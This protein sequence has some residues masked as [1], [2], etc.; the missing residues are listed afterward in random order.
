MKFVECALRLLQGRIKA[1]L[2]DGYKIMGYEGSSIY[3][4]IYV[5]GALREIYSA[6]PNDLDWEVIE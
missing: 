6:D 1:S 4:G 3:I 2:P 5:E